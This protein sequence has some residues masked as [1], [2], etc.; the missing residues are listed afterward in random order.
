MKPAQ[1]KPAQETL[2]PKDEVWR[3]HRNRFAI[4]QP[5]F[6]K[7]IGA[8]MPSGKF[9]AEIFNGGQ[10]PINSRK[11]FLGENPRQSKQIRK[12]HT[13]LAPLQTRCANLGDRTLN[14]QAVICNHERREECFI[15]LIVESDKQNP[16]G[17]YVYPWLSKNEEIN[18]SGFTRFVTAGCM[19]GATL[20]GITNSESVKSLIKHDIKFL[21]DEKIIAIDF[22]SNAGS[23][24]EEMLFEEFSK[25]IPIINK[26]SDPRKEKELLYHL[27]F[28][29]YML[30][31]IKLFLHDRITLPA[32]NQFFIEILKRKDLH[33]HKI[34]EICSH[35][36]IRV[37]FISPFENLLDSLTIES[38]PYEIAQYILERLHINCEEQ[39][40]KIASGCDIQIMSPID[41]LDKF[42][43]K[44]IEFAGKSIVLIPYNNSFI[45]LYKRTGAEQPEIYSAG[46]EFELESAKYLGSLPESIDEEKLNKLVKDLSKLDL[47]D[48]YKKALTLFACHTLVSNEQRENNFVQYCLEQLKTNG[49]NPQQQQIWQDFLS[50]ERSQHTTDIEALFK[51]GN[52]LVVGLAAKNQQNQKVCVLQALSEKQI[53]IEYQQYAKDLSA[54]HYPVVYNLTYMDSVGFFG[55]VTLNPSALIFYS[56]LSINHDSLANLIGKHG[57]VTQLHE[58]IA[59]YSL[60]DPMQ[61]QRTD[62]MLPK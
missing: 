41:D 38:T 59:E 24:Y 42:S 2:Q 25:V 44:E 48:Q 19:F 11:L 28:Y 55:Q 32:L 33:I 52:A 27:P 60:M 30:F 21:K 31:G 20:R 9:S 26:T 16:F 54:R 17:L 62:G 36:N 13:L 22:D 46:E 15:P 61:E 43:V 7:G 29:D 14:R 4:Y 18:F 53:Q 3:I 8:I 57:L 58:K 39:A 12:A 1:S 23:P 34:T 5:F 10:F 56:P 35:N 51:I 40:T 37:T 50:I 45:I 49:V 6:F 47:L